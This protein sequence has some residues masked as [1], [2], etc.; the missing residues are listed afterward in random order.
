M[1]LPDDADR[2]DR[3]TERQKE[4]LRL[5]GLGFEIKEIA[6]ELR[7][8]PTAVVERLRTARRILD[9]ESS[10]DAA[11]ML[12]RQEAIKDNMRHVDMPAPVADVT[13][14]P[15]STL[16]PEADTGSG[17]SLQVQEATTPFIVV[18]PRLAMGLR[19]WRWPWRAR[20]GARND[21]TAWERV[22]AS[23]MLM[24]AVSLGAA[25]ILLAI[26]QLMDL[27]IDVSRHGG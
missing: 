8:S 3:L 6:R 27:L 25:I 9:V 7:L 19:D 26:V 11:R 18:D 23:W 10:R 12:A 13:Y 22:L 20:G 17:A 24:A 2:I 1:L 5:V 16:Q 14:P 15:P 21:L 4:C